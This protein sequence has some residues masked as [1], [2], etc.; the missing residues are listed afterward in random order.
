LLCFICGKGDAWR[1]EK[2]YYVQNPFIR[3]SIVNVEGQFEV[4][5]GYHNAHNQFIPLYSSVDEITCVSQS[6][7]R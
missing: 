3:F 7:P 6:L 5:F 2:V 1:T 4:Y